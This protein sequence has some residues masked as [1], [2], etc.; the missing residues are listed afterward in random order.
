MIER[1]ID[2]QIEIDRQMPS[3]GWL[4]GWMD[5]WIDGGRD[6][7]FAHSCATKNRFRSRGMRRGR[8][9]HKCMFRLLLPYSTWTLISVFAQNNDCFLFLFSFWNATTVQYYITTN[10]IAV[11]YLCIQYKYIFIR[12]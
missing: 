6:I 1:D 8:V 2:R 3:S 4:D 5:G 9:T 12:G 7:L 10:T 11:L